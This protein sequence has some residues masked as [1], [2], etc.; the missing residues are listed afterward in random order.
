MKKT[1]LSLILTAT[2]ATSA[3]ANSSNTVNQDN[4]SFAFSDV[5]V[6]DVNLLSK[7]EMEKTEGEFG[8]WGAILGA[9]AGALHYGTTCEPNCTISGFLFESGVGAIGGAMS[10]LTFDKGRAEGWW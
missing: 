10:A 3:F 8:P 6:Q 5:K 1:L 4:L 9:G 7:Q 2:F